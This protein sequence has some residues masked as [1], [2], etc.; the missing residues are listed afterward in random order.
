MEQ[1]EAS[2]LADWVESATIDVSGHRAWLLVRTKHG[3]HRT[4]QSFPTVKQAKQAF[5]VGYGRTDG[6]RTQW[7]KI[8]PSI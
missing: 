6:K 2:N 3:T 1:F 4:I 5:S 7:K 8:K